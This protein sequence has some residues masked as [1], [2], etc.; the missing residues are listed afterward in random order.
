MCYE[1][2]PSFLCVANK[3]CAY[4]KRT[5]PDFFKYFKDLM[6]FMADSRC[7]YR[8]ELNDNYYKDTKKSIDEINSMT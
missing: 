4:I 1:Q 7:V 5:D 8:N 2:A 3:H 6:P